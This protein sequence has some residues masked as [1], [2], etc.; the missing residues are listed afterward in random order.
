MMI[1]VV[2]EYEN[3]HWITFIYDVG[4]GV[5]AAIFVTTPG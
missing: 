5:N 2:Y 4:Q 1:Y 3:T